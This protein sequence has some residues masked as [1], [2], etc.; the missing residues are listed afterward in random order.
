MPNGSFLFAYTHQCAFE[1]KAEEDML[2][3]FPPLLM[4]PHTSGLT[5]SIQIIHISFPIVVI[6]VDIN[7]ALFHPPFVL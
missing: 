2:L 6:F 7:N 4:I 5:V 3:G 1:A